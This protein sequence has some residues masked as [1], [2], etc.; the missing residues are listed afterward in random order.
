MKT[1]SFSA[2][3]TFAGF[4]KLYHLLVRNRYSIPEKDKIN[5]SSNKQKIINDLNP[6]HHRKQVWGSR[7]HVKVSTD[8][9]DTLPNKKKSFTS[10]GTITWGQTS[11]PVNRIVGMIKMHV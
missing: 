7:S 1:I 6:H 8:T 5:T 11:G 4:I 9:T 3:P 10:A 2:Y